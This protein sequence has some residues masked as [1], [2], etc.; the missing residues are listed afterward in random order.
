MEFDSVKGNVSIEFCLATIDPQGNPTN[1]IVRVINATHANHSMSSGAAMKALSYWDSQ[2]YFNIWVPEQ[3]SGGVLGYA[4]FPG[5]PATEDG[6]VV[7]GQ[8]FGRGA[9]ASTPYHLGRTATHEAGHWLNLHHT[10]NGGCAGTSPATCA[11]DGDLVCDTPPTASSNFGCPPTQN[12]CTE[13]PID[14]N[15]Q[16]VNYMDYGDDNCLVMFSKGQVARMHASLN[17]QRA[18]LISQA[19]HTATGCGCSAQTPCSPVAML[20][21]DNIVICPGQTVQFTD[22]SSGPPTSWIWTFTGGTPFAS[23]SANPSVTYNTPGTYTVTLEVTNTMGTATTTMTNYITVTQAAPPPVAEGFETVLPS[24]WQIYNEDNQTTWQITDTA[25]SLGVQSAWIDH[26]VYEAMGSKDA[27]LTRTIDMTNYAGGDLTFDHAYKRASFDFDTLNV[28]FSKDCGESWTKVWGRGGQ[29]LASVA[30]V[31]IG[32]G[33]VPASAE[34]WDHDTISL[35]GYLGSDG[36]KVKFESVGDGGQSLYLDNINISALVGTADPSPRALWRMQ[37]V[38]NPFQ[39]GLEV[40][41]ALPVKADLR[42]EVLDLNGRVLYSS[43]IVTA[44]PGSSS[45]RLPASFTSA[46]APGVYLLRGTSA[47]GVATQKVVKMD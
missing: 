46:L 44:T 19:N 10:F 11:L 39:N 45:Y 33:F 12:T 32:S 15:D 17:T 47:L 5:G 40:Q 8:H 16:T 3:I 1:G 37:T 7:T 2:K 38:P 36:F 30:G 29:I 31:G 4:T 18:T 26:F 9:C 24:D 20:S 21:A 25:A 6:I 13:T 42:F 41:Y 27:I 28:Y 43:P 34:E 14:H 22:Q 35:N 23:T